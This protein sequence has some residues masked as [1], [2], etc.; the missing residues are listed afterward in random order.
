MAIFHIQKTFI[1]KTLDRQC[2]E[3]LTLH[4]KIKLMNP[5]YR[6]G[7]KLVIGA[8][9]ALTG[10]GTILCAAVPDGKNTRK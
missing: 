9:F 10:L 3:Y 1:I 7:R 2:N 8:A 5:C 6:L 4:G